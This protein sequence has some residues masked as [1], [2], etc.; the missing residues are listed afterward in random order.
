MKINYTFSYLKKK[1]D[2]SELVNYLNEN[3]SEGN[4]I[5]YIIWSCSFKSDSDQFYNEGDKVLKSFKSSVKKTDFASKLLKY[6]FDGTLLPKLNNNFKLEIYFEMK[7]VSHALVSS[8][9]KKKFY[10]IFS[11]RDW[12]LKKNRP[13]IYKKPSEYCLEYNYVA[14]VLNKKPNKRK[15]LELIMKFSEM[16]EDEF[17]ERNKS[18]DYEDREALMHDSMYVSEKG[19]NYYKLYKE[20]KL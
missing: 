15:F 17:M 5:N 2:L 19:I 14:N 10:H 4:I 8:K 9:F 7:D 16:M 3:N 6:Q 11:V 1:I 13:I 18:I 12:N 20:G